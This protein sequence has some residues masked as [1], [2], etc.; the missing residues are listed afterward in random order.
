MTRLHLVSD[1]DKF[2]VAE[3]AKSGMTASLIG[4]KFGFKAPKVLAICEYMGVK[5]RYNQRSSKD[6]KLQDMIKAQKYSAAFIASTLGLCTSTVRAAQKELGLT[7]SEAT[8]KRN[9]KVKQVFLLCKDG[10]STKDAC[11]VIGM[12]VSSYNRLKYEI[13]LVKKGA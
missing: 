12:H 8:K 13:G 2:L 3:L 4:N 11:D 7:Y 1:E 6:A 5:V 9:E 10:M